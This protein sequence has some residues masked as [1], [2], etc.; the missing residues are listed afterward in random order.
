VLL[1]LDDLHLGDLP[2][3]R[4]VD[5]ALRHLR[6]RPLMVLALARPEVHA[7]FPG[8]WAERQLQEIPLPELSR[9]AALRLARE[10]LGDAADTAALERVVTQAAGN[11]F[12]LEELLRVLAA[13]EGG[14][15]PQTVL[16][17]AQ[18]RLEA[19]GANGRRLLRAAS[20]FGERF[21][22]G[23]IVAL[24]GAPAHEVDARLFELC[25]REVIAHRHDSANAA[26]V[27]YS[28]RH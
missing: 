28:V 23:G 7:N 8:L 22:R 27:E 1:V 16:A 6:D 21:W 17:M 9:K 19:V 5:A 10:V 24:G 4:L 18:A 3:V 2:T 14:V 20:I 11:A 13:G 25:E 12:Y 15:L 26:Q